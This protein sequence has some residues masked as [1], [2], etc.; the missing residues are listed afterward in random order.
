[1]ERRKITVNKLDF[2]LLFSLSPEG[3]EVYL[4]L[5][6]GDVLLITDDST[7]EDDERFA[8]LMSDEF[9]AGDDP[10]FLRVERPSPHEGWE[11]MADFVRVLGDS[12][13]AEVLWTAIQGKGAFGR[14]KNTLA[15]YP[16]TQAAWYA[17]RDAREAERMARWFA[18]HDLDVTF[19]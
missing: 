8:W 6:S 2:E 10:R 4:D 9:H 14:F 12:R 13:E 3:S 16:D 18:G 1:M 11:E 5:D 7:P 15:R 19:I 17:F